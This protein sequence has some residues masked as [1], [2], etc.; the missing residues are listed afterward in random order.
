MF[1]LTSENNEQTEEYGCSNDSEESF[2]DLTKEISNDIGEI[3]DKGE[4]LKVEETKKVEDPHDI[5]KDVCS[6]EW[7]EE[8]KAESA[9]SQKESEYEQ[10]YSKHP[11]S[12]VED[13]FDV[14]PVEDIFDTEK[15]KEEEIEEEK[16]E[17]VNKDE[18][19][20][21]VYKDEIKIVNDR[22]EWSLKSPASMYDQFYRQK[23]LF[24][25]RCLH[26]GQI[27][28]SR[29]MRELE[30]AEVDVVTE[31]FDQQVIIKQMEEVQQHRNRVKYI[32]VRV[33]NQYYEF[34]RFIG[35]LRGYLARIEYIKPVLKQEGLILEHMGDIELYFERL[36]AV[37][38]SVSMTEKNLAAS[39]EMLS[40]KVT[41]CMELPP[42]ER[43]EKPLQKIQTNF[44]Y[45]PKKEEIDLDG[46]DNLPDNAKTGNKGKVSGKCDWRDL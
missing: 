9:N 32:G 34:D 46:F 25:N 27:E 7:V 8:M 12:I 38:N 22:I 28:Y 16:V 1:D 43:Y 18:S 5:I 15:I 31:V 37:H 21:V 35:L 10:K 14:L 17:E 44:S 13:D 24:L 30:E 40:R 29:W 41:I 11:I 26:N 42:A 33:N 23:K 20:E 6:K 19:K 39:Y 3:K 4:S 45:V 36:R 2:E